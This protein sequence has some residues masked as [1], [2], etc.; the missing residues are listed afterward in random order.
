MS[1]S[2]LF[3]AKFCVVEILCSTAPPLHL[4]FS[5]LT[6]LLLVPQAPLLP[7]LVLQAPLLPHLVPQAPLLLHL[8]PQARA[9]PRT[10]PRL[11]CTRLEYDC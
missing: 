9:V 4:P 3:T 7:Q 8:V 11:A 2:T 6:F 5:P 10:S 1:P